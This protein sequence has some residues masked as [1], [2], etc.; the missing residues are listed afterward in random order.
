[1]GWGL[2]ASSKPLLHAPRSKANAL[3]RACVPSHQKPCNSGDFYKRLARLGS[4]IPI[5][6]V[7]LEN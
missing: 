1:M 6:S 2:L 5:I 7:I 3:A 4:I